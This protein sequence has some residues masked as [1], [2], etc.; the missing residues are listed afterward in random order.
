MVKQR[1]ENYAKGLYNHPYKYFVSC[2]RLPG[3]N[4]D[5]YLLRRTD[6]FYEWYYDVHDGQL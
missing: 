1:D 2:G 6:G 5:V 4:Q 3:Y